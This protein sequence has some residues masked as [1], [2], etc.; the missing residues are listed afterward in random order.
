M[1]L[2]ALFSF[3]RLQGNIV[4]VNSNDLLRFIPFHASSGWAFKP[5]HV[6]RCQ[7]Y[8]YVEGRRRPERLEV[9]AG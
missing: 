3:K 9:Q 6:I 2:P 4:C 1:L 8:S 7:A 5:R